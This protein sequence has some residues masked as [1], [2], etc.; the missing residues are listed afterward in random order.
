MKIIEIFP[1]LN[2]SER[3]QGHWEKTFNQKLNDFWLYLGNN[4]HFTAS[5]N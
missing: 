1:S 5:L 2:L 4:L 3:S